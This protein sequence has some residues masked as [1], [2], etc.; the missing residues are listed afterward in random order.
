VT[1]PDGVQQFRDAMEKVRAQGA[2]VLAMTE[3]HFRELA[4][5]ATRMTV[6]AQSARLGWDRAID[7][8]VEAFDKIVELEKENNV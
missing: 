2:D 1:D 6:E 8:V 4:R 3:N 5:V 7:V